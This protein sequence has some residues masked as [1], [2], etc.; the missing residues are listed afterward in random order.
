MKRTLNIRILA[1]CLV[2]VGLILGSCSVVVAQSP[3]TLA[4]MDAYNR[5]DVSTAYRLLSQEAKGGDP[6]AKSISAISSREVRGSP[7]IS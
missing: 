4:G 5:G 1:R 3:D 2:A 6:E 7:P